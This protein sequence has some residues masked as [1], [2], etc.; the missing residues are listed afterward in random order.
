MERKRKLCSLKTLTGKDNALHEMLACC[1]FIL[2]LIKLLEHESLGEWYTC[3]VLLWEWL[4]NKGKTSQLPKCTVHK[5]LSCFVLIARF[6]RSICKYEIATLIRT[7]FFFISENKWQFER[8]FYSLGI[9]VENLRLK[10]YWLSCEMKH[11]LHR[12]FNNTKCRT[13]PLETIILRC[14]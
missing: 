4:T 2:I 14:C 8:F 11:L 12:A 3:Y 1:C 13:D 10:K 5:K 7:M 9:I 6:I